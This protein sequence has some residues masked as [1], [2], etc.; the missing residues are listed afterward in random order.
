MPINAGQSETGPSI[1]QALHQNSVPQ[2]LDLARV[3]AEEHCSRF[4]QLLREALRLSPPV[5]PAPPAVDR[6][7]AV[8]AL[9]RWELG[10]LGTIKTLREQNLGRDHQKCRICTLSAFSLKSP[11]V[12]IH[13][14]LGV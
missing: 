6:L 8:A 11:Q 13:P 1:S 3:T 10:I 7:V 14:R 9:Q 5:V 12:P 4:L 2:G